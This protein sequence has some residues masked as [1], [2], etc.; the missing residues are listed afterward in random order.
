M[1]GRRD[2][3]SRESLTTQRRSYELDLEDASPSTYR[4]TC[5]RDRIYTAFLMICKNSQDWTSAVGEG[6]LPRKLDHSS[7]AV[8]GPYPTEMPAD[9]RAVA[10]SFADKE[11]PGVSECSVTA[12]GA[13]HPWY[14][15][16]RNASCRRGSTAAC[17]FSRSSPDGIARPSRRRRPA[18]PRW[19]R[20]S[21]S[22]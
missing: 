13:R 15:G 9:N 10:I 14:G 7:T 4:I 5:F 3:N 20:R 22:P 11:S 18:Q 6:I 19:R 2:R 17:R 21:P 8:N 12:P 1:L 16:F